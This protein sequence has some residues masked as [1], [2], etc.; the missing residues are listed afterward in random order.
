MS[1]FEVLDELDR[2]IEYFKEHE[3]S[4]AKFDQA[5]L[6]MCMAL[7]IT[8]K[9][10]KAMLGYMEA[11]DDFKVTPDEIDMVLMGIILGM[12]IEAKVLTCCR[13]ESAKVSPGN[14]MCEVCRYG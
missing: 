5:M 14:E 4:D 6:D 12:A 10:L 13:C 9:A 7:G 11:N 2:V 3:G 8:E 1:Q